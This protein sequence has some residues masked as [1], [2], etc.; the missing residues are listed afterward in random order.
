MDT[1][2]AVLNEATDVLVTV[3]RDV[4]SDVVS[5]VVVDS[6]AEKRVFIDVML[7]P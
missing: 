3:L 5:D 1:L 6:S 2:V 7:V 4:A